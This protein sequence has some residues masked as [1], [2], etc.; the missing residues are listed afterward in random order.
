[1]SEPTTARCTLSDS[2]SRSSEASIDQYGATL[3]SWFGI[4]SS[5]LATVFP[6]L[7]NFPTSNL[8]FLG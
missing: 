3:C 1:M 7:A 2:A 6:K 4:P 8:G 5:A